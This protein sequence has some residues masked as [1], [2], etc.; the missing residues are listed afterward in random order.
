MKKLN[1]AL[2]FSSLILAS[3]NLF[4]GALNTGSAMT[5]GPSSNHHSMTSSFNNPAMNPFMIDDEE[6]WRISYLPNIALNF[7]IGPVDNFV[8]DLDELIDILDDPNNAPDDED[9]SDL[10]DRLNLTIAKIGESGYLKQNTTINLPFLPLYRDS[11]FLGGVFGVDMSLNSQIG[12]RILADDI[13]LSNNNSFTS[14]TSVYLKSGIERRLSVSYGRSIIQEN[15]ESHLYAGVKVNIINLELSKQVTLLQDLAGEDI[16]DYIRDEYDNNLVSTT[17]IGI[18][19]GLVW[20][21]EDYRV[22]LVL[23]NLNAP[24]F[25]YGTIGEECVAPPSD[26]QEPSSCQVAAEFIQVKGYLKARETHTKN[27]LL[28]TDGLYKITDKWFASASLDLAA[29]DDTV[30]FENQW[31]HIATSYDTNSLLLPSARI[32]YQ[33]NMAGS[34]TSSLTFGLTLLKYLNLD[35]EYGLESATVDGDT[36]P[37]RLGF[38]IGVEERF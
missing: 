33:K 19:V 35:I 9:P 2:A 32:G 22:G 29:Y 8:D 17:N 6:K 20:D 4:A 14:S 28:R 3:G 23:E 34:K 24:S 18:D 36:Y 37:R 10:L 21:T 27:P 26:E 25:K 15:G 16:T 7:E 13:E 11:D 38:A 1:H 31:M 30:G 5:M 12:T